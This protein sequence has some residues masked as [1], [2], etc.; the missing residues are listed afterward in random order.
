MAQNLQQDTA[1][2][3]YWKQSTF[4]DNFDMVNTFKLENFHV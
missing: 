1:G 3:I 4:L 2:K